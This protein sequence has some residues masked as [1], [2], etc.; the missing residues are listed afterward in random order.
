MGTN[1]F[2]ILCN[3]FVVKFIDFLHKSDARELHS[4]Q[5]PLCEDSSYMLDLVEY[6]SSCDVTWS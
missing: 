4:T 2:I 3:L 1:N 5:S 6:T